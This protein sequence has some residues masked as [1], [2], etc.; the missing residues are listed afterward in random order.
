MRPKIAFATKLW[1]PMNGKGWTFATLPKSASARLGARG[2]V[3]I[4]GTINGFAFRSSAFPD[5]K[6]S[7]MIQINAAMRDGAGVAPGQ[8]ARFSIE[9]DQA[10]LRVQVPVDLGKA[11]AGS[12]MAKAQFGSITP[13]AKKSWVDWIVSAK[14]D[15]TRRRRIGEAVKRLSSGARWATE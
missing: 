6:G 9:L 3:S 14:Q 15:E 8:A 4:R 12:A 5:G 1:A 11:I 7:H 2:R 13:K 10:P